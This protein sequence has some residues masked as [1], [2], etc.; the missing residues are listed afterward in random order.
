MGG[1]DDDRRRRLAPFDGG[2]PFAQPLDFAV[3]PLA[4]LLTGP[5]L[6]LQLHAG[7]VGRLD[8]FQAGL[9]V[10]KAAPQPFLFHQVGGRFVKM[11]Q[12]VPQLGEA[13]V[14]LLEQRQRDE[15]DAAQDGAA[16][17]PEQGR[18]AF[19]LG[20]RRR[21]GGGAVRPAGLIDRAPREGPGR[22]DGVHLAAN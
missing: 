4:L 13:V 6:A 1:R 14:V 20:G 7:D 18:A 19:P 3:Q 15:A 11:L 5:Q 2:Q 22:G 9:H 12:V 17:A 16:D 8:L 10:G 21:A